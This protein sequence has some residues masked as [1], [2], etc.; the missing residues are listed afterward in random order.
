MLFRSVEEG[1]NGT[2]VVPS[3]PF[4]QEGSSPP[5][6]ALAYRTAEI[7]PAATYRV[8]AGI[9]DG[10]DA[11]LTPDGVPVITAGAPVYGVVV[12]LTYRAAIEEGTV[13][14]AIIGAP[15]TLSPDAI[16]Q[17]FIVRSD[18]GAIVAYTAGLVERDRKSTRLNSSH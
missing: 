16:V 3:E 18:T 17:A 1:P 9:V 7:D 10:P 8:L 2:R 4:V 14:G 5:A 12:P 11:W 13:A 6:F 15:A